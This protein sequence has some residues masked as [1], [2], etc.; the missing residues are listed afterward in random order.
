MVCLIPIEMKQENFDEYS[1]LST[2]KSFKGK[3]KPLRP[4]LPFEMMQKGLELNIA[5]LGR[6][7]LGFL[8]FMAF[9]VTSF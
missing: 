2:R 7:C 8:H 3:T 5:F 4:S 6:L 9:A 1:T